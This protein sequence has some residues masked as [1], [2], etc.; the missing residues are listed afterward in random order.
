MEE[1]FDGTHEGFADY[2]LGSLVV[3]RS[4]AELAVVVEEA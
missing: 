1:E 3:A 2:I 4:L